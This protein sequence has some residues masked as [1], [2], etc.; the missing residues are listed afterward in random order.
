MFE[1]FL[2][3]LIQIIGKKDKKIT[4]KRMFELF[5]M[6]KKKKMYIMNGKEVK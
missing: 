2:M 1:L 4:L 5:F 3:E 6:Q